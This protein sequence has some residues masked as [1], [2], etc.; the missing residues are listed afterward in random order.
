MQLHNIKIGN[1]NKASKRV[2]RGGKRGAYSGRG[3]KGQQS[4]SGS[5]IKPGFRGGDQPLWKIFP[6][7]RGAT[8]KVAIRHRTFSI[9]RPHP[10][11]VNLSDLEN[12]FDEGFTITKR[13]IVK[14]GLVSMGKN[15]IKV[16]GT[17]NI[18]K[19]F[20]FD[21]L[22]FSDSARKKIEEAG[23]TI[24]ENKGK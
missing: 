10:N 1:K 6:K 3:M 18:T 23:G 13:S 12:H 4:R 5:S 7:L 22:L 24:I 9:T 17:G 16:L 15:G 19:K 20:K 2:G 21:G 14:R 11:T 8:K